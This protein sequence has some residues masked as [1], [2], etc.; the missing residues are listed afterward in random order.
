MAAMLVSRPL[1]NSL[2]IFILM[3]RTAPWF[4]LRRGDHNRLGFALQ[5]GT[6]RF[7]GAFLVDPVNIPIGVITYMATQLGIADPQ[8]YRSLRRANPDPAGTYA[9]NQA[10]LWL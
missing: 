2:A 1:S 4:A 8:W 5:I 3:M 7:L 9:R 6:L 10:V